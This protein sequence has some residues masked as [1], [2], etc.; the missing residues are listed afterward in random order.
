MDPEPP[1]SFSYC[2]DT[3][4][5]EKL[6]PYIK[7]SVLLYHES[8]FLH[9]LLDRAAATHHSTALQAGQVAR[10]AGVGR[11]LLGHFSARYKDLLPLLLEA[12][13]V[14]EQTQLARDGYVYDLK[15]IQQEIKSGENIETP[16][17]IK[18]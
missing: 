16:L 10:Q 17:D 3:R 4:Y 11:L 8:T 14:F 5:A 12:R 15:R 6:I 2:S 7:D 1:L 18:S 13:S 9:N